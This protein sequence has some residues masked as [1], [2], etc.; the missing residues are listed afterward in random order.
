MKKFLLPMLLT[1]AVLISAVQ[2]QAYGIADV[3]D[4][5][6][7]AGND[8]TDGERVNSRKGYRVY[9]YS[10]PIDDDDDFAAEYVEYLIDWGLTQIGHEYKDYR[11]TS[12][13]SV[14]K[15]FFTCDGQR[16]EFWQYNYYSEGRIS[17]SVRVANGLTYGG[18]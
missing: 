13:Q 6:E 15:W 10:C 7:V 9:A 16:V 18:N 1:F 5:R 8:V 12:A 3:P 17:F 4:F 14:E 11:R 2:V